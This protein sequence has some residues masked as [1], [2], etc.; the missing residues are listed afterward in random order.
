MCQWNDTINCRVLVKAHLSHTG[1]DR[2]AIKPVDRCIADIVQALND[3]GIYTASSCCGHGKI[4]GS[5]LLYDGRELVI[6]KQE[7]KL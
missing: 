3:A 6:V 2:W 4:P 7:A 5:I 1:S